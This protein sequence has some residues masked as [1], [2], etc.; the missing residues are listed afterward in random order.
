MIHVEYWEANDGTRFED[1]LD[2]RL[3]EINAKSLITTWGSYNQCETGGLHDYSNRQWSG[4]I[5]DYYKPR[6]EIWLNERIKELKNEP[7]DKEIDWFEREWNWVLD[8]KS[9]PNVPQKADICKLLK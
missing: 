6:W 7:A 3:Y 2:C 9:Y 8:N 5:K 1:E 4:L